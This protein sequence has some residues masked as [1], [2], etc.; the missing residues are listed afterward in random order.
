MPSFVMSILISFAMKQLQ[1]F[2]SEINWAQVQ[3][4][5]EDRIKPI[6]PAPLYAGVDQVIILF[7]SALKSALSDQ[8][9]LKQLIT[10]IA[11]GNWSAAVTMIQKIVLSNKSFVAALNTH[12]TDH[13]A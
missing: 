2:E 9:D 8:T 1:K 11:A 7:I 10:L 5:I 6:I 3:E 13:L 12:P 4:D